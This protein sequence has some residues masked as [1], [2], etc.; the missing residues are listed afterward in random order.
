MNECIAVVYVVTYSAEQLV[1]CCRRK[2]RFQGR[3]GHYDDGISSLPHRV[4]RSRSALTKLQYD[5][6]LL[7]LSQTK[8]VIDDVCVGVQWP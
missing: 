1:S 2:L 7:S 3:L 5:R 4:R 6:P 8:G